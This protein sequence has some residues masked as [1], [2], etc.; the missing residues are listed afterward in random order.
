MDRKPERL[1]NHEKKSER[2]KSKKQQRKDL[3]SDEDVRDGEKREESP[4]QQKQQNSRRNGK[5][6][7]DQAPTGTDEDEDQVVIAPVASSR[8][9]DK[10]MSKSKST[11]WTSEAPAAAAPQ[12]AL[13]KSQSFQ[14]GT[15]GTEHADFFDL[16]STDLAEF[17]MKP[18]PQN[19]SVKCRITRDKHGVDRGMYPTYFMHF[20]KDDGKKIFLLAARK[21]KRSKTSNYLITVDAT[22]LKR[23]GDNFIGKL[24]A[25]YLGTQFTVYD[26]GINPNKNVPDDEIREELISIIYV[27]YLSLLFLPASLLFVYILL[28]MFDFFINYPGYKYSWI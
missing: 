21:R 11:S 12:T 22:D 25:N 23:D 18:A 28:I 16:V 6:A 8:K 9:K 5:A 15:N 17:V 13:P 10:H 20:E 27:I 4:R 24:R 26:G 2:K 3:E 19:I 7:K 14:P 1:E